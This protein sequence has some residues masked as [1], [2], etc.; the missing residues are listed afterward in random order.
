MQCNGNS[1]FIM[2][3]KAETKD[4]GKS[5]WLAKYLKL[6]IL[7]TSWFVIQCI[8]HAIEY[9]PVTH[10]KVMTLAYAAMNFIIYIF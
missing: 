9:L 8:A 4:R 2:P 6:V 3:T 1:K 7:Q 5:N 10:L